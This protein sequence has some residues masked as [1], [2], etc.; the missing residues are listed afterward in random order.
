MCGTV[1]TMDAAVADVCESCEFKMASTVFSDDDLAGIQ[2]QSCGKYGNS[3]YYANQVCVRAFDFSEDSE[4]NCI[5][6]EYYEVYKE[7]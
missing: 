3:C 5:D 4:Y 6:T 1:E 2:G 7:M